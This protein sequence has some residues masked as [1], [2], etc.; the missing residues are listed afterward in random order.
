VPALGPVDLDI[1]A[2]RFVSLVGPS[3]CGKSTLLLMVAGLLDITEGGIEVAGR[4]VRGPQ[5]DIGIVF[6]GNVLV[7]WRDAIGNVLL[8]IEMRGLKRKDYEQPARDLLAIAIPMNCRAA[9]SR[10][11]PSA[12]RS[13]TIRR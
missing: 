3:G 5:T 12:G 7:D 4:A 8:Q 10:E 11:R 13:S 1:G 9:C 6:Q 2:G